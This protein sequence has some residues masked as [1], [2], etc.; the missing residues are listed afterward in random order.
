MLA[1]D[2]S[3]ELDAARVAWAR[4]AVQFCYMGMLDHADRLLARIE[5]VG[6]PAA[7]HPHAAGHIYEA[8]AVRGEEVTRIRFGDRAITA[9]EA[10]GDER[11]ACNL[12][13]VVSFGLNELGA[14]RRSMPLLRTTLASA[15]RLGL[16]NV[17]ATATLQLGL[18]AYYTGD[19]GGAEELV[20]SALLACR[21]QGNRLMEGAG[22]SY[23]AAIALARGDVATAE[24]HAHPALAVIGEMWMARA[25]A[26]ATLAR[27]FL[28][29]GATGE[30]LMA[31]QA[32]CAVL[33]KA[34]ERTSRKGLVRLVLAE[35]LHA[36]GRLGEAREALREARGHIL[37]RA[38]GLDDHLRADFLGA[39]P[40][41]A[42][43]LQWAE[44][45]LDAGI[46]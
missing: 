12:R 25:S 37:A 21:A 46:R 44:E 15:G 10:A 30:A 35:A 24:R 38:E 4:A 42:R 11:N 2:A 6:G 13:I 16:Q 32:A 22:L 31:A 23:L 17:Q 18:A 28:A 33:A 5:S 26:E 8:L 29:Q 45:W 7:A 40:E 19:L 36:A 27:V 1:A 39:Q 43:T 20:T 41:H 9:F 3:L 34:G 14:Y